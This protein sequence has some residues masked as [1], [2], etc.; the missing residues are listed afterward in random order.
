LYR[1]C[2]ELSLEVSVQ[3]ETAIAFYRKHGYSESEK[4]PAYYDGDVDGIRMTKAFEQRPNSE[5]DLK[6]PYFGQSLD[7]TC[8]PASLLMAFKHFQPE[9]KIERILELTIWRES[10]S[11]FMTSGV[12]GCDP[13]GL[14]LAARRRG[15][16]VRVLLSKNQTPFFSSVRIPDK[17]R[18]IRLVHEDLMQ[19]T[20]DLGVPVSWFDFPFEEIAAALHRGYIPV[21]LVSTWRLSGERA[22]HW[23]V[24]HGFDKKAVYINDPNTESYGFDRSRA[25]RVGIP[26]T[27]FDRMRRYGKD[28]YKSAIFI[29]P[30]NLPPVLNMDGGDLDRNPSRQ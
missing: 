18:V 3:N 16:S 15:F 10:T 11:I 23:V 30:R 6:V 9:L 4:L 8:G 21:V 7:F 17:R 5:L 24:V 19:K 13:F 26:I 12:G 1:K 28:L 20:L 25:T 2:E 27:D 22:P 14:A 29:G